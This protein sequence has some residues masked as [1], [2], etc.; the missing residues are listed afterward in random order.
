VVLVWR[1]REW[2]VKRCSCTERCERASVFL[3]W[4]VLTRREYSFCGGGG[5][6]DKS[7]WLMSF[8]SEDGGV[9]LPLER[10]DCEEV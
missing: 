9:G 3:N 1:W 2:T 5:G 10:V 6:G 4:S 8:R 7:G